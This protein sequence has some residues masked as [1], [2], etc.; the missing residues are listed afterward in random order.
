MELIMQSL[1]YNFD[2][3]GNTT[4]VSALFNGNQEREYLNARVCVKKEDLAEGQDIDDLSRK[5]LEKLTRAR[6]TEIAKAAEKPT[7]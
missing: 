6:L 7:E 1:E 4:C 3:Q 5:Q 2:D